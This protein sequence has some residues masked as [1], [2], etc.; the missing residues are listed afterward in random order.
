MKLHRVRA[1]EI[2]G[3]TIVTKSICKLIAT[4]ADIVSPCGETNSTNSRTVNFDVVVSFSDPI[5]EM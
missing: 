5:S 3:L 2:P 1:F 4:A